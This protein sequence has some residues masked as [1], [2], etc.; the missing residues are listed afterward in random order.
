MYTGHR[1]VKYTNINNILFIIIGLN[2]SKIRTW[3]CEWLWWIEIHG[4]QQIN[5]NFGNPILS[6]WR[7]NTF[8]RQFFYFLNNFKIKNAQ[9]PTYRR[10]GCNAG[11][12]S[13]SSFMRHKNQRTTSTPSHKR[14]GTITRSRAANRTRPKPVW[15]KSLRIDED[16]VHT[17]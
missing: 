7:V 13:T 10:R 16:E 6:N 12:I 5:R 14:A 2:F 15:V 1:I 9:K 8:L 11:C 3:F 4:R 17:P